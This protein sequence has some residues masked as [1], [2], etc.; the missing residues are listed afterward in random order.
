[1]WT[2]ETEQNKQICPLLSFFNYI[3][4]LDEIILGRMVFCVFR[5]ASEAKNRRQRE[6]SPG[7]PSRESFLRASR[8]MTRHPTV[9]ARQREKAF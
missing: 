1:L 3:K 9:T 5:G 6:K 2:R 8:A 7:Q 4:L